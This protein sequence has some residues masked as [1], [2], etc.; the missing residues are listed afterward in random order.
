MNI[1]QALA[2]L[3]TSTIEISAGGPGS[4]RHAQM[5][6]HAA[7][8]GFY[9]FGSGKA[10]S[11]VVLHNGHNEYIL[12][13]KD[14]KGWQHINDNRSANCKDWLTRGNSVDSFK[15]HM[16]NHPDFGHN[17]NNDEVAE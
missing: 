9:K 5:L 16:I 12:L 10:G 1:D 4:G 6:K 14:G 2:S 8:A 15:E 3:S 17:K 7:S 11:T 13:S